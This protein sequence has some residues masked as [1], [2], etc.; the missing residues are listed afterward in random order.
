[1]RK[2]A[3]YT[4]ALRDQSK[5]Q[6]VAGSERS[7]PRVPKLSPCAT[8]PPLASLHHHLE[9]GLAVD[10]DTSFTMAMICIDSGGLSVRPQHMH[11]TGKDI[12]HAESEIR[13]TTEL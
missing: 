1:M 4:K 12:Q 5:K 2:N 13:L 9:V 3:E 11:W 10:M 8:F 6:A 7:T